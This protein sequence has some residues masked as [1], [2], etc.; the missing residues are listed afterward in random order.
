[1]SSALVYLRTVERK[2]LAGPWFLC[3][4]N[5]RNRHRD[6]LAVGRKGTN[7]R[8][9]KEKEEKMKMGIWFVVFSWC[10]L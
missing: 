2:R 4:R 7:R 5:N 1:L 6:S 8:K 10:S 3:S 9:Q